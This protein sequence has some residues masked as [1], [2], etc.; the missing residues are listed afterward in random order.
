[1]SDDATFDR[2]VTR[3]RLAPFDCA[4]VRERLAP[5]DEGE[6][7]AE[8]R[9][10]MLV[11]LAGC[12]GCV[13]ELD[14]ERSLTDALR[15]TPRERATADRSHR[16]TPRRW[17]I[18]AAA[19]ALLLAT[20][21]FLG[22]GAH[23]YGQ[24]TLNPA[25]DSP[26]VDLGRVALAGVAPRQFALERTNHFVVAR[27]ERLDVALAGVCN[28]VVDGPARFE[29][30]QG[31]PRWKLVLLSG[32]VAADIVAGGSLF[33]VSAL[34]ERVVDAGAH[35]IALRAADFEP[36][37]AGDASP[38]ELLAQ[39]HTA[40]YQREDFVAAEALYRR[41]V[42]HPQATAKERD[43]ALFYWVA[44]IARQERW[45]A[46]IDASEALLAASPDHPSRGWVHYF[47][48][49]YLERLRRA[50][51]ANAAYRAAIA[52]GGS[53]DL[54]ELSKLALA[55]L[56]GASA[57]GPATAPAAPEAQEPSR[58]DAP[59]PAL[60]PAATVRGAVAV[61]ALGLDRAHA[62]DA[63]M[64]AVARSAAKFHDAE[65]V[66]IAL[67]DAQW[68]GALRHALLAAKAESAL[69][70]VAPRDLDIALHRRV[71]LLAIALDD[72]A[73]VDC[74]FGWMTARDGEAVEALWKRTQALRTRG[75]SS[76]DWPQTF[77]MGQ[78]PSQVWESYGSE[79]QRAAGFTT[80]GL[81][82]ATIEHDKGVLDFVARHLPELEKAGAISVTGNGDPQG[83]WLFNDHRNIDST[84]HWPFDA[85][86]IGHDPDGSMPRL[87]AGQVAKLKLD[88][89][90]VWSGT[91]HSAAVS[92]V[93]V[94]GDIV[95]TF[96]TVDRVTSYTLPPES[97]LALAWLD[98]GA[99]ALLAPIAAN[100]GFAV[101][102]EEEFVLQRGA[103]LG[104]AVKSSWDDVCLQARGAP[105][106]VLP[107]AGAP[108]GEHEPI[109]QGGGVNRLLIGD[110]TL[111][112]FTATPLSGER[113]E[114][115]AR[116]AL[117]FDVIVRWD[118]QFHW[119]FWDLYGLD[120]AR[121]G[122]VHAQVD[123]AR[124]L[125]EG[126]A[127]EVTATMKAVDAEGKPLPFACTGAQ[128][129]EFHGR[130]WL[131]LQGNAPR[132]FVERRAVVA[133][134][135]VECTPDPRS[136]TPRSR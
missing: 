3:E 67:A 35:A 111:A 135:T 81:G 93:F 24:A 28:L 95:S 23:A 22:G 106:L 123:L 57:A 107:V 101:S 116:G 132:Q 90:V 52:A 43:D 73:F 7:S 112:P 83:I 129:E 78:G 97:S 18:A 51:E 103:S 45:Q 39:G 17:T 126:T 98:A 37:V 70:F 117:K 94:E 130:R 50:Q 96:G 14:A 36:Q 26:P 63:R 124:L 104:A 49:D 69:L 115:V 32:E 64:L 118:A 11:H 80:R 79:Q 60:L 113:V 47:R 31:E 59:P 65:L 121:D 114:I 85:A 100:H 38:A 19:A 34:G 108:F 9:D 75:L 77:V 27:G 6:L 42:D 58:P 44:A 72:D 12:T 99:V 102:L 125:P 128:P 48:G 15:M 8:E 56:A 105:R 109:M 53:D 66:E 88:R 40:F 119:R 25:S 5:F 71:L 21:P 20:L 86:R 68:E 87:L 133:T 30:E 84:R 131:H 29:L 127:Y 74:T 110:P 1:M 55:R 10:L 89:P 33:V 16:V 122:R 61:V 4:A 82:F 62:D 134:F 76:R 46:A 92:R 13:A 2:D 120:H 41:A 54:T 136:T 91:C